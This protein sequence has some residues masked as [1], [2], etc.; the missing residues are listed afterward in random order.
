MDSPSPSRL[1]YQEADEYQSA[2]EAMEV[3]P[4]SESEG[5]E[6]ELES[7]TGKGTN[8]L[9]TELL[10]LKKASDEDFQK[11][12]YSNYS[13]FLRIFEEFGAIESEIMKLKNHVS[14]Q[15]MLV[16]EFMNSFHSEIILE[17]L[18]NMNDECAEDLEL[19]FPSWMETHM[20]N[21]LETLDILMSE[22]RME[23]AL[24][25]LEKE[26]Q[27]FQKLQKEKDKFSPSISLF[28]RA[29]SDWRARL[30]EH[31]A[32]LAGHRRV[33]WPELHAALF[34]L[35][36]LGENDRACVL[37]L[38]F[39]HLQL[40]NSVNELKSSALFPKGTYMLE[41]TQIVFSNIFR[42]ARSFVLLFE[43]ASP[44]SSDLMQWAR[45]E[46]D[47]IFHSFDMYVKSIS[48]TSFALGLAVEIMT[49]SFSFCSLLEHER[50]SLQFDVI[51][52]MRPCITELLRM[53][54][55]QLRKVVSL[56][57]STDNWV[58]GKF[59]IS[60]KLSN[61]P[62]LLEINGKLEYLRLTSSGRKF[63]TLL[64]MALDDTFPFHAFHLENLILE[65]LSD[66]FDEYT[67]N[68][69]RAIA[70]RGHVEKCDFTSISAQKLHQQ[71][72]IL[73]NS[74]ELVHLLPTIV[75]NSFSATRF[76]SDVVLP[77]QDELSLQK[78]LDLWKQAIQ[79]AS[80]RL[81]CCFCLLFV[82]DVFSHGNSESMKD[83]ETCSCSHCI[84][85]SSEAPMPSFVFQELFVR[86]R[87]LEEQLKSI[88]LAEDGMTNNLL[89][90]ILLS[91]I[92]RL[93]EN[94][95]FLQSTKSHKQLLLDVHFLMEMAM[96]G[97]YFSENLIVAA[98]DLMAI[99]KEKLSANE[100][101]LNSEIPEEQWASNAAKLAIKT[102]LEAEISETNSK[103]NLSLDCFNKFTE[104]SREGLQE[105]MDGF[106]LNEEHA[107]CTGESRVRVDGEFVN[108]VDS[109]RSKTQIQII[110]HLQNS[111]AGAIDFR[112]HHERSSSPTIFSNCMEDVQAA[113]ESG[114]I[115]DRLSGTSSIDELNLDDF[116]RI[117]EEESGNDSDL[118]T[119]ATR[120]EID[121]LTD[122]SGSEINRVDVRLLRFLEN[123]ELNGNLEH[124]DENVNV[125]ISA[126]SDVENLAKVNESR[127]NA[128]NGEAMPV[129]QTCCPEV[130]QACHLV[131]SWEGFQY[132]SC[133]DKRE[134]SRTEFQ[135][136]KEKSFA[137]ENDQNDRTEARVEM[138]T[139]DVQHFDLKLLASHDRDLSLKGISNNNCSGAHPPAI[140]TSD[141]RGHIGNKRWTREI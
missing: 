37:L 31:F 125:S 104:D 111:M 80:D 79:E 11:N 57:A 24:V 136:S 32:S 127:S 61:N 131:A 50:F 130:T 129:L 94:L 15:S 36:R 77:K 58:L 25:V 30:A 92:C 16:E 55:D 138:N 13:A 133:D 84:P 34:G 141:R 128:L 8:R 99:M 39:F 123:L 19:D 96:V 139:C 101:H 29:I 103:Y 63:I 135:H 60:G 116:I 117:S 100:F 45:V 3:L 85:G 102:L 134:L 105:E 110:E 106:K 10:E 46:L 53:H 137:L 4:D 126:V 82:S 12:I 115:S 5:Y 91:V 108:S 124:Q 72:S 28:A 68:L 70:I 75:Q 83:L 64:Q 26:N 87:Q 40:E 73:V 119:I 54:F 98:L 97:G 122:T 9:C 17:K 86:L 38:K 89:N 121:K 62:H 90:G 35:C 81:K 47:A 71:I 112:L 56:F 2:E 42:A 69:E 120:R 140:A 6:I 7:M 33:T 66:L 22:H 59:L 44:Y 41:L 67:L 20:Q 118:D 132:G 18:E 48:E 114:A 93:S 109:T 49:I 27:T 21:I 78:G 88:L 65:G 1:D 23:E 95:E 107:L 51:K 14:T 52:L 113:A 74:F 43:E 76:S